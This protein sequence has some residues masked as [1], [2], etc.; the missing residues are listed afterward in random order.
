M[1]PA[2][3]LICEFIDAHKDA[4]GVAPICRALVVHGAQIAP[5]TYWAHRVSAPSKRALWD[6]TITEILA[7][8]YE[9]DAEGKRPPECLYGSL[10]MWAH[11]QR[12]DIP[13]ARCTVEKIMRHN[14]WRGVTRAR[15]PPRT[16]EPD[17]GAARA[18]DLVG[19]RWRVAAP[20]LLE[21]ADFTYVP[22]TAGFGYTAF[23][24]DAYAGL[25]PGW[26]CSLRKDTGFVE[27]ALRHAVAFR[28]RRGHPFDDAIHHSD[29][30][31]QYT[32]IHFGES[33]MLAGLKPSIGSVGDALDNGLAET[34]IGLYKTECVREGSPFRSGPIDTL[35][36]LE[37]LT[38][39][40][41]SWYNDSRLMHRLGR[42]A[43]AEAEAEYYARLLPT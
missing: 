36:D 6:T 23:V 18:P 22:M 39:A 34:T 40:W 8:Y 43:P 24:I 42:R 41:V 3:P 27:R 1:R 30:G 28:A 29:A 11:L 10:K 12:Q 20:N 31:S 7:G 32:A 26:E 14:G 33:L 38:S 37:N 17:P 21:V 16:T 9:P 15:R 35:S 19:R 2:T 13:V 5:R 4:Y 25:I